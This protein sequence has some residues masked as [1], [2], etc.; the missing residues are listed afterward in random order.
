MRV[1]TGLEVSGTF[2]GVR[3]LWWLRA[4]RQGG[5]RDLPPVLGTAHPVAAAGPAPA[6]DLQLHWPGGPSCGG[7]E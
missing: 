5:H 3:Y 6:G 1:Q 4:W 2:G 7:R